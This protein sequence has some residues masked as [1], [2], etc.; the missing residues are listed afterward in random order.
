MTEGRISSSATVAMSRRQAS[1]TSTKERWSARARW[2]VTGPCAPTPRPWQARFGDGVPLPSSGSGRSTAALALCDVD[3]DGSLDVLL[4]NDNAPNTLLRG[5]GT[6]AFEPEDLPGVAGAAC[7]CHPQPARCDVRPATA[8]AD[9]LS[10]AIPEHRH[11]ASV[12]L[13][14]AGTF[15]AVAA[16]INDVVLGNDAGDPELLTNSGGSFTAS[17]LPGGK[18]ADEHTMAIAA[19]KLEAAA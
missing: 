11:H 17:I 12:Y 19:G 16:D 4:G 2:F 1:F 7:P 9:F 5:D 6:G 3:A 15:T 18:G 13:S 14:V 8:A 10:T